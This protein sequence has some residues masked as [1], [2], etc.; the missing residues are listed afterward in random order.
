MKSKRSLFSF[1]MITISTMFLLG[2]VVRSSYNRPA[3]L[4]RRVEIVMILFVFLS[5]HCFVNIKR[6]YNWIHEH[7]YILILLLFVFCVLN[8]FN[9][10]SLGMF[11]QYIQTGQGSEFISP[12][13]GRARAIRSDEWMVN[14]PR[15]LSAEY[16]G[17]GTENSLVRA[18]TSTNLVAS[19]GLQLD[20]AALR[21][22]SSWGY[23]IFGSEYGLSF[24]WSFR[25]LFGFLIWYELFNILTN[26]KR[27]LSLFGTSLIWF[28][29]FN[30]WWSIVTQIISGPAI[31]VLFYYFVREKNRIKRLLIGM[32][33]AIAGADYACAL[34]PAWQVP[35]GYIILS[36][37][38]WLLIEND[39]WRHYRTIDWGIFVID[40]L[41]MLSIIA[42]F[43]W[44]D[45][46]YITGISE[47]V[48]PG[49]RVEYGGMSVQKLLG[50]LYVMF[51]FIMAQA[52][53]C[54]M[55]CIAVVF[56]LGILLLAYVMIRK[57]GRNTLLLCLSV[58]MIVLLLYCTVGLPPILAKV[59]LMTYSTAVRAVDY[60]GVVL[61]IIT[62]VCLG[63]IQDGLKVNTYL[64][65]LFAFITIIP[66]V[67]YCLPMGERLIVKFA[68]L[69]LAVLLILLITVVLAD[70]KRINQTGQVFAS[71]G[72]ISTGMF[73]NP[74]MVGTDAILS[75]PAAEVIQFITQENKDG[76]WMALN[77]VV[78]PQYALA[79]GAPTINS[80]NYIPNYDMWEILDSEREYEEIWNRYAHMVIAFSDD[81]QSHY[82]LLGPDLMQ[83][84]LNREDF[85]S[86][87]ASYV[88]TQNEIPDGWKD[89][90]FEKYNES[91][92]WIYEV[93]KEN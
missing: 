9:G 77:S 27:L 55:S 63:E 52:N 58:P 67:L 61:A 36:L 26:G 69:V 75:K 60:L 29:T 42:R 4:F 68:M 1:L 72:L 59:I 46:E 47:T 50:Y 2:L 91:G 64:A 80:I 14:V 87:D 93:V 84:R 89:I 24:Q 51:A 88:I 48:Y 11:D 39:E 44:I 22:P 56:P 28:S 74:I 6:L 13:L 12:V 30:M 45:M 35:M 66:S 85:L 8:C 23:Y 54:E 20:Y 43:I 37:M 71:V 82:E 21:D 53:P 81:D 32:V 7:R 5:L 31:V 25:L 18:V 90:L 65:I 3:I 49:A 15:L 16:S 40:V 57:K 86:L 70:R 76:K 38:V 10:S 19:G 34:Y 73:V 41:F 33:L 78:L 17:Y 83:M 92:I 79:C 62:I